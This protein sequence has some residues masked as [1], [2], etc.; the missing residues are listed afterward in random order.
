MILKAKYSHLLSKTACIVKLLVHFFDCDAISG[1]QT[2]PYSESN[3]FKNKAKLY[4]AN[5]LQDTLSFYKS[6]LFVVFILIEVKNDKII[7][8]VNQN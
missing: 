2:R 6:I 5:F 1:N 4:L 7:N 8:K 3:I